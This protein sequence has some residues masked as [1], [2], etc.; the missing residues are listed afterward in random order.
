MEI[1][2]NLFNNKRWCISMA[3]DKKRKKYKKLHPYLAQT[4][5]TLFCSGVIGLISWGLS[6]NDTKVKVEYIENNIGV[7]REDIDE[8][9]RAVSGLNLK[10]NS[11]DKD[12]GNS[13]SA[14]RTIEP[15]SILL[16]TTYEF[17]KKDGVI[18]NGATSLKMTDIVGKDSKTNKKCTLKEIVNKKVLLPYKEGGHEV[19]FLGQI[20]ENSCWHGNCVINVYSDDQLILITDAKYEHGKLVDY[21]QVFES[22]D[23]RWFIS[24]RKHKKNTNTGETWSYS[25]REGYIKKFDLKSVASTDIMSVKNFKQKFK[26]TLEGYYNGN[27][28]N[29]SYNDTTGNAYLVKYN[30]DGMVRTLYCGM[31]QDGK[32]NDLTA[33]AWY[34]SYDEEN[35]VYVYYKGKFKNDKPLE[36]KNNK[37]ENITIDDI[38]KIID[39]R[40]FACDVE[41]YGDNEDAV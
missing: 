41:L 31:F 35:S 29:G 39:K 14:V 8:L 33:N 6:V 4:I 38:H 23:N 28:S 37:R 5:V 32:F 17:T 1:V 2:E 21:K 36:T 22:C 25:K 12:K 15:E 18:S 24:N 30:K 20:D 26:L 16:K 27:T 7:M 40:K 13:G 34:I 19:Y 9:S 3:K 10:N 11:E